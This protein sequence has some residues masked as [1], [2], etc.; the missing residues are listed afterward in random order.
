MLAQA[1]LGYFLAKVADQAIA[2]LSGKRGMRLEDATE[3]GVL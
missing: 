3:I 2:I 1:Q